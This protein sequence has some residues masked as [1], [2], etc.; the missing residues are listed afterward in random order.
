M[1]K[2][3]E[4]EDAHADSPRAR[5][6]EDLSQRMQNAPAGVRAHRRVTAAHLRGP[7]DLSTSD[8]YRSLAR[9]RVRAAN[10]AVARGPGSGPNFFGGG[11]GVGG[12]TFACLRVPIRS[13]VGSL[14]HLLRDNQ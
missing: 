10:M 1:F 14:S 4:C 11:K 12:T 5:S 13:A 2:V 3:K 9:P 6:C 7:V 8:I